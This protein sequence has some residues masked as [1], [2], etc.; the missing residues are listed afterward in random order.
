MSQALGTKAGPDSEPAAA[1]P[2]PEE[3][4]L[5]CSLLDDGAGSGG[6]RRTR[7]ARGKLGAGRGGGLSFDVGDGD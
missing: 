3:Y 2:T 7:K 5:L 6:G 4:Q 1:A